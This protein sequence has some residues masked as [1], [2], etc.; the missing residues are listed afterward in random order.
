MVWVSTER[1]ERH[2]TMSKNLP[3]TKTLLSLARRLLVG[4]A[5]DVR[6]EQRFAHLL[7]PCEP[8]LDRLECRRQRPPGPVGGRELHLVG[9]SGLT[10]TMRRSLRT[11]AR[12]TTALLAGAVVAF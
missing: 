12:M 5:R 10:R 3:L 7:L 8:A 9:G 4:G 11:I 6:G 2:P 1:K